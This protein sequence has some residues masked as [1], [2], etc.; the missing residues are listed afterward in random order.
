MVFF[1]VGVV[2]RVL[3]PRPHRQMGVATDLEAER[4]ANIVSS[5]AMKSDFVRQSL[6]GC[7]CKGEVAQTARDFQVVRTQHDRGGCKWKNE[8][9]VLEKSLDCHLCIFFKDLLN[10]RSWQI[11]KLISRA[12]AAPDDAKQP[13]ILHA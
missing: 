12:L 9:G 6:P 1:L 5:S 11:S 8:R 13:C 7:N 3:D 2:L 10:L 4:N